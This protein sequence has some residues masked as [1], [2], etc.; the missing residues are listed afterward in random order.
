[1]PS[2]ANKTSHAHATLIERLRTQHP[3]MVAM[4]GCDSGTYAA[5]KISDQLWAEFDQHANGS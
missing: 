4:I 2:N 3:L 1:M 5:I